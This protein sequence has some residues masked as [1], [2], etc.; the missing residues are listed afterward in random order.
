MFHDGQQLGDFEILGRLGQGGMGAVYQARQVSLDRFVALK[1]L[2][3]SLADDPEYIARFRREAKAAAGLNHPNLVQVYAAGENDGLH[4]FAMEYVEGESAQDRLK[5]KTRLDPAE[6]IAIGTHIATALEYGWRKAHLIHRDIKPDNIF[7]S[8]DGEVKLGDL[9]LAKNAD[10]TMSLTLSGASMGTPH[11]VSPEQAEGK[12]DVDLR[13]DIYSLGCTLFHLVAG[14]QPFQ[15]DSALAVMMKHVTAPVPEMTAAWPGSPGELSRVVQKM[16]QKD[17]AARQ[18]T[19]AEVIADLRRAYDA[20]TGET[21]PSMVAVTQQPQQSPAAPAARAAVPKV[22]AAGS[23]QQSETGNPKSKAPLLAALAGV[24]AILGIVAWFAFGKKEPQLT[25]VERA[26]KTRVQR[27]AAVSPSPAP[28]IEPWQ[29]VLHDPAKLVLSGA[30]ERTPEGLRFTAGGSSALLAPNQ[31][32]RRDGAVRLRATFGGLRPTLHVRGNQVVT[33]YFLY[34]VSGGKAV[35]LVVADGGAGALWTNF[36][37]FPLRAPLE[38]GQDYELELRVV[39]QTLTAKFNGEVLGTVTDGTFSEGRFGVQ[40]TDPKTTPALVKSLEV[41][42]LDAPGKVSPSPSPQ[43]SK[44]SPTPAVAN[45]TPSTAGDV[46]TFAGHRYQLVEE[47]M[48]WEAAKTRAEQMGGHLATITSKAEDEAIRGAFGPS[49]PKGF[50]YFWLGAS[51]AAKGLNFKWVT[52]EPFDYQ[53]WGRPPLPHNLPEEFPVAL[54]LSRLMP[55]DGGL[56]GWNEITRSRQTG[57]DLAA[58]IGFLVE[59][60]SAEAV[61]N[62]VTA[63]VS[64][65]PAPHV[66]KSSAQFP[67]GRW[68]KLPADSTWPVVTGI[69]RFGANGEISP[70]GAVNLPGIHARDIMLRMKVRLPAGSK[71]TFIHLRDDSTTGRTLSIKRLGAAGGPQGERWSLQLNRNANNHSD[72]AL[73]DTTD[74]DKLADADGWITCEFATIG[75]KSYARLGGGPFLVQSSPEITNAGVAQFGGQTATFKDVEVMIF[76][77]LPEAEALRILGV[78]E[79]GNDLRGKSGTTPAAAPKADSAAPAPAPALKTAA[80]PAPAPVAQSVT[81]KW[82]AEQEPGWQGAFAK[83]VSGPF[84]KGLADLKKQYLAAVETQLAV[85]TK[86]AKLD[87]AVAFRAERARMTGGGDVPAEDEAVTPAA[88]AKLRASYRDLFAKLDAERFTKAKGVHARTD[89]ILAQSQAGL[90]QKARLDEALEIKSEREALAARWLKPPAATTAPTPTASP[91]KPANPA[92]A[93]SPGAAATPKPAPGQPVSPPS[94][95]AKLKPREVVER[96]LAMGAEIGIGNWE[97]PTL[98]ENSGQL[99]A[100]KFEIVQVKFQEHAGLTTEDLNIVEQ[101][102]DARSLTFRH[103]PITDATLEKLRA[104]PGLQNVN[105]DLDQFSEED[106]QSLAQ[107]PHLRWV[108]LYGPF[109]TDVLITLGKARKLAGLSLSKPAFTEQDFAAIAGIHE[110]TNLDIRSKI[111]IPT[112]AWERLGSAKNLTIL[113]LAQSPMSAE[114]IAQI[115]KLSGLEELRLGDITLPDADLA[116][117]AALKSLQI[118]KTGVNSTVDGSV[119]AAWPV[120]PAMRELEFWSKRNTSDEA[121]RAIVAAFPK[122]D[123]LRFRA[124]VGSVT[125]DG[126]AHLSKLRQLGTLDIDGSN[127]VDDAGLSQLAKC[128]RLTRLYV[129]GGT[130]ITEAGM[131]SLAKMKSLRDL[132]W[133]N[134]PVTDAA[135]KSFGKLPI[136]HFYIGPTTPPENEAKLKAAL[137]KVKIAR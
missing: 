81:A 122:L 49:I 121:L 2:Q 99:P 43:S 16:M 64:P 129:G 4:W 38:P 40:V 10:E 46:F 31:G 29:D 72:A 36:P 132:G 114:L 70:S 92:A 34:A 22:V 74:F 66:S 95:A 104:L 137:P 68:M 134:R 25:E 28:N 15:G 51:S 76:D 94:K 117:L 86:A 101:L 136:T 50:Q 123:L 62:A 41:L 96:L 113:N 44:S 108:S 103:V 118:L 9:G 26:D 100:G 109:G 48:T 5:R 30:V 82:I 21:V 120:R 52:G 3:A 126:L 58:N 106:C 110:L 130:S 39:G 47:R 18:Q 57:S 71:Y 119:F 78:D 85:V 35:K 1:T 11:Y 77:G 111:L 93:K 107:L 67:P 133:S 23:N 56:L 17:P 37:E 79:K 33:G 87:D 102:T 19:Y 54:R 98:V 59:W 12:K 75:E 115:S 127:T 131:H 24:V 112:V 42:D 14:T 128:D 61:S 69:P 6:A 27:T 105:L 89:A 73:T 91:G 97:T 124:D 32:P 125:P 13:A 135:L 55:G 7:L 53:A 45:A 90:T 83:E 80:P 65:S 8:S 84:E 20:L 63:A 116:P 60:D 88:L